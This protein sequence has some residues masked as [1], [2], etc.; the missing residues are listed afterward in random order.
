MMKKTNRP[1]GAKNTKSVFNDTFNTSPPA[2]NPGAFVDHQMAHDYDASP[3]NATNPAVFNGTSNT[4]SPASNPEALADGTNYPP[5]YPIPFDPTDPF[6]NGTYTA[7]NA[8]VPVAESHMAYSGNFSLPN[9]PTP[10][11]LYS[12]DRSEL[13]GTQG[14]TA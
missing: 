4:N 8:E 6:F 2:Q 11:E 9:I 12:D 13:G 10:E 7:P 1:Q 14:D 3:P 5:Y